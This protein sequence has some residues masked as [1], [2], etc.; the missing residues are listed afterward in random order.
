MHDISHE[1]APDSKSLLRG[2]SSLSS[3]IP[4]RQHN[5][6][7]TDGKIFPN[8]I[9]FIGV[10]HSRGIVHLDDGVPSRVDEGE[11]LSQSIRF[12]W[13]HNGPYMWVKTVRGVVI[14]S[15][16]KDSLLVRLS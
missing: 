4:V 15:S 16:E 1:N 14:G 11:A 9:R 5:R 2:D 6:H 10:Q 13:P 8:R 3:I 12:V 7:A